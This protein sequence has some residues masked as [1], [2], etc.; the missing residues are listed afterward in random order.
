M[1]FHGRVAVNN[2]RKGKSPMK[3]TPLPAAGGALPAAL[4]SRRALLAGLTIAPAIGATVA[5]PALASVPLV[6][7]PIFS[8]I[9]KY[10][11]AREAY[12]AA[13]DAHT[14]AEERTGKIVDKMEQTFKV[15]ESRNIVKG[16]AVEREPRFAKNLEE[17]ESHLRMVEESER[18]PLGIVKNGQKIILS[19]VAAPDA[20]IEK[21]RA[22]LTE[23]EAA[24]SRAEKEEKRAD[25]RVGRCYRALSEAAMDV[26]C[27][28]PTSKEGMVAML[29]V[30]RKE[31]LDFVNEENAIEELLATFET[32]A[33]GSADV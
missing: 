19:W 24:K 30:W 31:N 11:K 5:L 16:K 21:A 25:R 28:V 15:G 1:L 23:F 32:F 3:N 4:T 12:E 27:T 14:V 6:P 7:D 9:A 20:D 22:A 18:N 26:Y 13:L 17:L 29:E 33:K 8:A 2:A 10:W